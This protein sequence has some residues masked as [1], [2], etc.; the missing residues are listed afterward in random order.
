MDHRCLGSVSQITGLGYNGFMQIPITTDRPV[1]AW[2]HRSTV[3]GWTRP[4]YVL[5]SAC[6]ATLFVVIVVWWSRVAVL[7]FIA[8]A[9]LGYF[10][11]VWSVGK[12]RLMRCPYHSVL[13]TLPEC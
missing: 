8:K 2:R 3:L 7:T 4:S 5:M 6:M 12:A 11:G 1:S 9:G 13:R 10:F